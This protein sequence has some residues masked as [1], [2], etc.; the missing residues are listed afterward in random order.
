MIHLYLAYKLF[1]TV[2][3]PEDGRVLHGA[4]NW[5][6]SVIAEAQQTNVTM[7]CS[8]RKKVSFQNRMHVTALSPA[9]PMPSRDTIVVR[10]I[11][12][13]EPDN[14]V[15]NTAIICFGHESH[16]PS[17]RSCC[18]LHYH[19]DLMQYDHIIVKHLTQQTYAVYENL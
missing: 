13:D 4:R 18:Q 1:G 11:V 5:D 10:N 15:A 19:D 17:R 14:E 8:E 3:I 9:S 7:F 2:P 12:L 6:V 16:E